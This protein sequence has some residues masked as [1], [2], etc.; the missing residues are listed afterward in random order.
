[1]FKKRPGRGV[2][3]F[4]VKKQQA[5]NKP[6]VRNVQNRVR[7]IVEQMVQKTKR[8][9]QEIHEFSRTKVQF[10]SKGGFEN[11]NTRRGWPGKSSR[12]G[13]A[14]G[15]PKSIRKIG[16]PRQEKSQSFYK[17]YVSSMRKGKRISRRG[18][19]RGA[20]PPPARRRKKTDDQKCR[21][22]SG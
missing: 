17:G 15:G 19:I 20:R 11:M 2:V 14:L 1:L 21:P 7:P 12:H 9:Q 5:R 10:H 16:Q 13:E 22:R 3:K 4:L 8:L 18:H 6:G